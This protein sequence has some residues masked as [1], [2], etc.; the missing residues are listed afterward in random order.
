MA[1]PEWNKIDNFKENF[2]ERYC[3]FLD[4]LGYKEKAKLYFDNQLNLVARIERA[5]EQVDFNIK[6]MRQSGILSVFTIEIFSD[7][8]IMYSPKKEKNGL[9]TL[10]LISCNLVAYLSYEELFV[11]GGISVGKHK[12]KTMKYTIGN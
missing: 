5:L 7:S 3:V 1:S 2:E 6:V 8:I 12:R 10:L 4:I 9:W 11:R